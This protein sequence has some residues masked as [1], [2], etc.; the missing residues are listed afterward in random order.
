[1]DFKLEI[2]RDNAA[3]YPVDLFP[4]QQLEYD[5][6]FYDSVEIDKV[7]LP[8]YTDLRIPL[9]DN[10]KSASVFNFEPF[11]DRGVDFP[12][13]DFYFILEV[14]GT[15]RTRIAGILNVSAVEYNSSQPY[16]NVVLKD[17][18]SKYL[19]EI[20]TANLGD[21]YTDSIYT[22]RRTFNQFL[23]TTANDGEAGTIGQNPDPSRAINFPFVD[24]VN[25][26]DG[27]FGYAARQF[28][29][30]GTGI[31]RTGIMPTFS[32]KGFLD[33]LSSYINTD[34][35]PFRIDS[36][37]LGVGFFANTPLFNNMQPEKLQ[38][39][40]PAQLLAKSDVNVRRFDIRQSPA[41]AVPNASLSATVDLN[42]DPKLF[43]TNWFSSSETS[44]NYGTDGEGLPVYPGTQEW[45]V[46][47]RM[48]FYPCEI[49]SGDEEC[50]AIRGYF[51]P[52]VSFNA[53]VKLSAGGPVVLSDAKY[54]I[55]VLQEDKMVVGI[56]DTHPDTDMTFNVCIGIW[57]DGLQQ[58]EITLLDGINGNNLVLT[59][60]TATTGY[61]N[62]TTV[63]GDFDYQ[64]PDNDLQ[65]LYAVGGNVQDTLVFEPFTAYFPSDVEMFING[66]SRYS[67]NYY[68]KPVEG[69]I[70]ASYVQSFTKTGSYYVSSSVT[71]AAFTVNDIRKAI[72]RFGTPQGGGDYG[73]FN[74]SFIAN[75]DHLLYKK[76]D[77]FIIQESIQKTCPYTVS[78]V[79]LGIAKRFD[80]SL[81]YDYDNT[82]SQHILR[83][84]PVFALRTTT[85]DI[86]NLIDDIKSYKISNQGDKVKTLSV[87]NKDF[88]LYFDDLN[89]D[90]VTIG[91]TTQTINDDGIAEIKI[92]LNSSIYYRS[93]CGDEADDYSSNQNF[94]RGVFSENELGFT[95]NIF[96]PNKDVGFRF[97]YID[98]PLYA[99]NL[100]VPYMMQKGTTPNMI[101]ET[102]RIYSGFPF[103]FGAASGNISG[104]HVFNGR[105]FTEN[106]AGWS[107]MFE[108]A[109]GNVTDTYSQILAVSEKIRQSELPKIEFDMVVPTT[110]LSN[111]NF[112]L[113]RFIASRMTGGTIYVK[114]AS[115]EVYEDYAYLTIEGL[116]E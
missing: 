17:Y 77:E 32:V 91:S 5:V 89:N 112:F 58:K 66:G 85:E 103:P 56:L 38:M 2:S 101:T 60:Y 81:F 45:G 12:K 15:T 64:H 44:G 7:K 54:E 40:L 18:I 106:T 51:A 46:E 99:T 50:D 59:N 52:K 9:T 23:Q 39:I 33:T 30:Y 48:G 96:T 68:L 73:Q 83:L 49:V 115:G 69:T 109:D 70:R 84:D 100:L 93:V 92:D 25:D 14:Y 1:M 107:L 16:L 63:G 34:N 97:A 79:L 26:I 82:S 11:S 21:I 108:D 90:D 41:W 53:D 116:L 94:Q 65:V 71:N 113:Q 98:K 29:E 27:K 10:N 3:Y 57:E 67:I 102:E 47:K 80:C 28:L 110:E 36:H 87:N 31:G 74:I 37:L 43:Y 19:A 114:S 111:L 20:K 72:T 4:K 62:K 61:S 76:T 42:Q 13:D 88:G 78:E 75:E 95:P 6:D 8:F 105:L 104:K 24:F 35:F 86:N 55:P 22:Q